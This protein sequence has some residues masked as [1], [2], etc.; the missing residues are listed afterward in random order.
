MN[1]RMIQ[2]LLQAQPEQVMQSN[3]KFG[4]VVAVI[5]VIFIGIVAYLIAMDKKL[6]KLEDK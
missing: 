5:A 3:Q 4:V 6:K 1:S 2:I